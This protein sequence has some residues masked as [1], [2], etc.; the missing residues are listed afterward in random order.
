MTKAKSQSHKSQT[1]DLNLSLFNSRAQ[2]GSFI[3]Q[4][5]MKC[6]PCAR[7]LDMSVRRLPAPLS[8][9]SIGGDR[10]LINIMNRSVTQ[11]AGRTDA[12]GRKRV[13]LSK[14]GSGVPGGWEGGC[15]GL[16]L[17]YSGQGRLP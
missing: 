4:I 16:Q 10:Q 12:V 15:L 17:K 1:E 11:Y 7:H 8:V 14:G 2:V 9:H 3:Q 13:E 5:F 6:L